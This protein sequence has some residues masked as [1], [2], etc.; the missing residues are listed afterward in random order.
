MS[1]LLDI[2]VRF[3]H[4]PYALCSI[5]YGVKVFRINADMRPL[6]WQ[7]R[8]MVLPGQF[9]ITGHDVVTGNWGEAGTALLIIAIVLL[10]YRYADEVMRRDDDDDDRKSFREKISEVVRS[11]GHRLVVAPAPSA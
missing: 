8:P 4:L 3:A 6:Y 7:C 9:L 11:I 1:T 10:N 2:I 5:A